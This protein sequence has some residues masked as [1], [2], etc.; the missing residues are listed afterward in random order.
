M[1]LSQKGT[2][3]Y[4]RVEIDVH[5]NFFNGSNNTISVQ[6][7]SYRIND[8]RIMT[9]FTSPLLHLQPTTNTL[10]VTHIVTK[11]LL[12]SYVRNQLKDPIVFYLDFFHTYICRSCRKSKCMSVWTSSKVKF[13]SKQ[14]IVLE[15]NIV[16]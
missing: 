1:T 16:E 14:L 15:T 10:I 13:S 4:A 2:H 12:N 5:C 3:N 11:S 9:F 6:L 8:T 7:N